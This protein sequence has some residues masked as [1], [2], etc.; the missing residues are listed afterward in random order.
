M[1]HS[2]NHSAKV[3]ELLKGIL[4]PILSLRFYYFI[5]LKSMCSKTFRNELILH[6]LFTD[7][8][9]EQS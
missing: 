1:S 4:C 5:Y 6:S 2:S 9:T 7:E 3:P 8:G